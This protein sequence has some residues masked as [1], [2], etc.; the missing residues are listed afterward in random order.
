[1]IQSPKFAVNLVGIDL[2]EKQVQELEKAIQ[3]TTMQFLAKLDN[4]FLKSN[5]VFAL[6]PMDTGGVGGPSNVFVDK[7]WWFGLKLIKQIKKD[8]VLRFQDNSQGL[9]PNLAIVV[10]INEY[11]L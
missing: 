7:R 9:S 5:D 4:G 6:K 3:Q 2:S 11:K 1:M 8:Q 10:P